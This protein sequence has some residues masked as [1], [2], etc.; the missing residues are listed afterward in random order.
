MINVMISFVPIYTLPFYK[1]HVKVL[2]EI[3]KIQSNFLWSG[4]DKKNSIHWVN[5]KKV[6]SA[7]EKGGLGIKNTELF[8]KSLLLK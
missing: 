8:N 4:Y 2:K 5:C 1:A 7:K 6:C 3:T